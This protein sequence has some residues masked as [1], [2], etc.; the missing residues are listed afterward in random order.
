MGAPKSSRPPKLDRGE[1]TITESRPIPSVA[2]DDDMSIT[3]QTAAVAPKSVRTKQWPTLLVMSGDSAGKVF[4]IERDR[5]VIGRSRISDIVLV[6]HGISRQ[7]FLIRQEGGEY[8]VEDMGSTN[9]TIVNG[10]RI[11]RHVLVAGDRVQIGPEVVLQFGF[12]D[13]AEEGLAMRLYE[14]ATR[15]PLTRAHNRRAFL[16]RLSAEISYAARHK[17]K[18]ALLLVDVDYFKSVNDSY[19]HDVGDEVLRE[20]ARIIG[21]SLRNEDVFARWG[22]EEFVI[23]ARGLSTKNGRKLGERV[24]TAFEKAVMAIQGH[25]FRVTVSIGVAELTECKRDERTGDALLRLADERL[26][27]AK[28]A[29][30]NRVVAK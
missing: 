5:V 26:Y 27:A 2:A 11:E 14:A 21:G 13:D 24:R 18:L 1:V 8:V 10:R 6:D 28:Q 12:F 16:E 30:R 19:G 3:D 9:G 15:D 7:H 17:E 22:G 23:L 25:R 20:V 29:G 4:R